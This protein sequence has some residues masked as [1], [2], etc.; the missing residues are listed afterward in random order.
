MTS[1]ETVVAGQFYPSNKDELLK[2]INTF[3]AKTK[4]SDFKSKVI[5]VPHAGYVYSGQ[6]AASGFKA[7]KKKKTY[8]LL[9]PN[10][11]GLGSGISIS[12]SDFWETPLG[13][14]KVNVELSRIIA[15]EIG[16]LDELSHIGEHSIEVQLPFLQVLFKNDFDIVAI[17]IAT[18]DL[19]ELKHLGEILANASK[20]Y[21]F[22]MVVSSDFSHFL[23]QEE[24]ENRD[25]EAIK[26]IETM[27]VYGFYNAVK[28]KNMSIC[29]ASPIV[30]AMQYYY[31]QSG[32]RCN[33]GRIIEYS[34]SGKVSGDFSSVVGYAAIGFE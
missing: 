15:D 20:K 1:R 25:F 26:Y 5:I 17:S 11:T 32:E 16:E 23:D 34:T 9:G 14:V 27:D 3:F 10:H 18:D 22:G 2:E 21:D 6:V 8:V 30:S 24:T 31:C 33:K 4:K 13:Q 12:N 29:G 19:R 28:S 7:L